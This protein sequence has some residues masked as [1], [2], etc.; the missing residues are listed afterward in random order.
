MLD[1]TARMHAGF[2][3]AK[4]GLLQWVAHYR[5]ELR[6]QARRRQRHLDARLAFFNN[7]RRACTRSSAR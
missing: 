5:A 2:K 6:V 4:G 7:L 1:A 3:L